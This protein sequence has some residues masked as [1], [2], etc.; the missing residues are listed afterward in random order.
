MKCIF[1]VSLIHT[2][3]LSEE[4]EVEV[5]ADTES[6]ARILAEDMAREE[7]DPDRYTLDFVLDDTSIERVCLVSSEEMDNH[8]IPY[9]R[10][11]LTI[12]MFRG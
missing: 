5:E 8:P 1:T 6:E 12:D 10:C 3:F 9:Q 4:I 7:S 11:P 2:Y